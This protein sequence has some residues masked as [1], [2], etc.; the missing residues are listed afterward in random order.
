MNRTLTTFRLMALC[1]CPI[2]ALSASPPLVVVEDV[3]GVSALPF[4]RTLN[5]Q[6]DVATPAPRVPLTPPHAS[7][8]EASMLPVRSARLT[9]GVVIARTI[10]APGLSPIFIVGDDA[11]SRLWL[12]AHLNTLRELDAVGIV[13]NVETLDGLNALRAAARGLTL[14]PASGDDLAQRLHLNHYPALITAT[15]IEP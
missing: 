7:F 5:L 11:R 12:V 2:P 13:V 14:S 1:L 8:S 10:E 6:V 9:P 4:Y 15:G 3:G